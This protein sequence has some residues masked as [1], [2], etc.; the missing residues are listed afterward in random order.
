MKLKPFG[1][2]FTCLSNTSKNIYNN[3]AFVLT[4][5]LTI[6]SVLLFFKMNSLHRENIINLN[7]K[8]DINNN[9]SDIS[10][11][12]VYKIIYFGNQQRYSYSTV[13]TTLFLFKKSKHTII[14]YE[15]WS[16]TMIKSLGVPIVAFIDYN[17]EK[18]ILKKAKKYNLTGKLYV[19]SWCDLFSRV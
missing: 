11:H 17:W 15:T 1:I 3:R 9:K 5:F 13:V 12:N 19:K 14:N 7:I 6:F 8:N 4:L 16:T 10:Y 2:L 18:S